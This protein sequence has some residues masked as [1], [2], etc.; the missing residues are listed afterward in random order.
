[1]RA[2]GSPGTR[3][4]RRPALPP[5]RQQECEA[6]LEPAADSGNPGRGPRGGMTGS[7]PDAIVLVDVFAKNTR[8]TPERAPGVTPL[9]EHVW[10]GRRG[11]VSTQADRG[12]RH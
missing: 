6:G 5:A 7:D 8:A 11:S 9:R 1:M 2:A 3:G 12:P 4:E 10:S